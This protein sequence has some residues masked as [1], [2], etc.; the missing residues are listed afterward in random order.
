MKKF[1]FLLL[2]LIANIAFSQVT[3][4]PGIRGGVN[5]SHY[6]QDNLTRY[7]YGYYDYEYGN[8]YSESYSLD[9]KSKVDFYIGLIGNIRLSRFYA[10]QPEINYSRQGSKVK[11]NYNNIG[12]QTIT[13][14]Y[15]G[16]QLINKFYIKKFN[17][18][19]GPTL[20]FVVDNN[21]DLENE[22][23]LGITAGIGFD[24]NKNLGVEARVKKGFVSA[25]YFGDHNTN[26]VFQ[27]GLYY[28]FD[29]K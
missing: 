2:F 9:Y 8:Y 28:T 10:L 19:V 1:Y 5:V 6:S 26:V 13:V 21:F 18:Q 27:A 22:I 4:R 29:M 14:S 24:I 15:L 11:S 3:F 23:D 7:D 12:N 17:L 20:D 25:V 16:A